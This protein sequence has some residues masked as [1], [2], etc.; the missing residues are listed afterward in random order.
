MCLYN[1][2]QPAL[3]KCDVKEL[4]HGHYDLN[5]CL[6]VFVCRLQ[7]IYDEMREVLSELLEL[8]KEEQRE[9]EE[10]ERDSQ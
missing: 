9:E 4:Q 7:Q 1:E 10:H 2:S 8:Q 5:V 6:C 3:L